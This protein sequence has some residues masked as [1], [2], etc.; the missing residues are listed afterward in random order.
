MD[1]KTLTREVQQLLEEQASGTWLD[2]KTTYDFLY[3]AALATTSRVR[4]FTSSQSITTVIGQTDYI[5]NADFMG[6]YLTDNMNRHFIKYNDGTNDSFI[7]AATI[8]SVYLQDNSTQQS[9][10]D[11]FAIGDA[12]PQEQITGSATSTTTLTNGESSLVDTNADFSTVNVGDFIHNTTDGSNGV[13]QQVVSSTNLLTAS[14]DGTN[15]FWSSGDAYIINPQGRF[16]IVLNPPPSIGTGTI[17]IPYLQKPAPVYSLYRTYP[18]APPYKK[19][20]TSLAA[21]WYKYRDRDPKFGDKLY[22][23]WD[24]T[25]KQLNKDLNTI[26]NRKGFRVNFIKR[27]QRTGSYR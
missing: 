23:V 11:N 15:N 10:P 20:I 2:T 16:K 3:D 1:G 17:T 25:V 24:M 5:L 21:F 27:A 6:L 22:Q 19:A 8:D 14:F 18:F 9:V 13:V 7:F 12:G 4:A 26:M